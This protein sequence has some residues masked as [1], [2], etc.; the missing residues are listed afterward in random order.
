MNSPFFQKRAD[1]LVNR[2]VRESETNEGRINMAYQLLYNR[3][4]SA[5]ES[6]TGLEFLEKVDTEAAWKQ[7][8]QV[9]LGSEEFRYIE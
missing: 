4:P 3:Q 9:L 6:E 8:A 5:Y 2:L 1:A 7:Y